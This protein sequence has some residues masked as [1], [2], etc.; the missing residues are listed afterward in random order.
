[1]GGQAEADP[2]KQAVIDFYTEL[3]SV[4]EIDTSQS[5]ERVRQQVN[6]HFIPSVQFVLSKSETVATQHCEN[7]RALG[8]TILNTNDLLR[9]LVARKKSKQGILIT[10]I[11]KR[12]QIIPTH[13]ILNL[14]SSIISTASPRTRFL[15]NSYP[16]ALDTA[17]EFEKTVAPAKGIVYLDMTDE[18]ALAKLTN[19]GDE[20]GSEKKIKVFM[21]QTMPV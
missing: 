10:N 7:A 3:A 1:M 6:A 5:A 20:L 21:S 4:R 12:G 17:K 11:L 14:L 2:D 18:T 8:Y 16:R 15:I 19:D 13:V 9:S